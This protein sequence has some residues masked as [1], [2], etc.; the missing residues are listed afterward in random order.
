M[1][2]H[3]LP[4]FILFLAI[5]GCA[6]SG[7]EP[8]AGWDTYEEEDGRFSL[9]YIAP[10]WTV[11][12]D[13]EYED[14][15]HECP[16]HLIGRA[17]C[18][19]ANRWRVLW[20]PPALLDPEFLLIPPYKLEISWRSSDSTALEE[21][22]REEG[23]MEEAGLEIV[24][25]S[26]AVTLYDGTTAAE[27]AYRGPVHLV[28]DTNPINRPD[29]RDYRVIYVVESGTGYRVAM[30]TAIDIE[31]PEVRDMLSSFSLGEE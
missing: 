19:G 11:C 10:P 8:F 13:T 14:D 31:L 26:R 5:S 1:H 9:R 3:I 29:E 30:D 18:G 25:P 21:T 17:R 7:H 15:C 20:V 28:V 16:S 24:F 6:E 4:I 22:Q 27:V 2:R 12:N 23:L